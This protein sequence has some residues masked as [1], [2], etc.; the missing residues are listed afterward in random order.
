M[1]S[2]RTEYD[3]FYR[4]ALRPENCFLYYTKHSVSFSCASGDQLYAIENKNKLCK[5]NYS[6]R[7]FSY[8]YC[9]RP[10]CTFIICT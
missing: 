6:G 8:P 1:T 7:L 9:G 3:A 10:L 5:A 2:T 4:L